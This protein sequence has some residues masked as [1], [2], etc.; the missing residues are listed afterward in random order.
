MISYRPF[1]E[2][3]IKKGVTEYWLINKQGISSATV[4][5]IRSGK[6]IKTSTIDTLC[7]ILDCKVSDIIEY[8]K[9]E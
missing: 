2:T 5:Q 6:P 1:H 9:D 4:H 7:F 8:V 3:L